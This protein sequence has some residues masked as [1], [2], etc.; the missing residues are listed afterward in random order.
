LQTPARSFHREPH[1]AIRRELPRPR[2]SRAPAVQQVLRPR[3]EL[4]RI[5]ALGRY[6]AADV[7]DVEGARLEDRG[8][9]NPAQDKTG[10]PYEHDDR[11]R[12]DSELRPS[13]SEQSLP[14]REVQWPVVRCRNAARNHR[15]IASWFLPLA[16]TAQTRAA[17]PTSSSDCQ[18]ASLRQLLKVFWSVLREAIS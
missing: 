11:L 6:A 17:W 3:S 2:S 7:A 12:S 4:A 13:R 8:V 1:R 14:W 18:R 5:L 16:C 10:V 15:G 9:S